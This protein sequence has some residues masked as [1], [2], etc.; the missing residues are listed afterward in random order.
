MRPKCKT[1]IVYMHT[2]IP[3][4]RC[5]TLHYCVM[6]SIMCVVYILYTCISDVCAQGG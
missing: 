3:C 1:L 6:Y 2:Y 5:P 4:I